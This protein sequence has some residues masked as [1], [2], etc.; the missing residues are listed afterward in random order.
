MPEYSF[1]AELALSGN[2]AT[3][4]WVLGDGTTVTA[5]TVGH[6]YENSDVKQVQVISPI[7]D[8][9]ALEE[10]TLTGCG[11][12][13]TINLTPLDVWD[14][15]EIDL[16]DNPLMTALTFPAAVSGTCLKLDL[17][18][19]AIPSQSFA[20]LNG[21]FQVASALIDLSDNGLSQAEVDTYL[22]QFDTMVES[23]YEGRT[24]DLSGNNEPPSDESAEA[25][26]SLEA[27]GFTVTV[28]TV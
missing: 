24:I 18:G 7:K 6:N 1:N 9:T 13:G 21:V 20:A 23:G 28:T 17:S 8:W 10:L 26:A 27:K 25:V 19:C 15:A 11:I 2:P 3:P 5:F 4:T 14:D 12:V 16:S 22:I